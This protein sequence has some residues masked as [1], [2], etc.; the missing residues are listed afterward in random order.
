MEVQGL[1]DHFTRTVAG[2]TLTTLCG[3]AAA[4]QYHRASTTGPA[5]PGR[6]A[7]PGRHA[8]AMNVSDP[9]EQVQR[10]LEPMLTH[11]CAMLE[12]SH[13]EAALFFY[14]VLLALRASTCEEEL[15]GTFVL[16][17]TAAFQGL[18]YPPA[19]LQPIDHLLAVSADI[20]HTFMAPREQA[21]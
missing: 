3:T 8:G 2:W 4:I 9:I 10:T 11:I 13:P 5:P 19:A 14:E 16:L 6:Q 20:A 21:H 12:T 15:I 18:E 17:S 7:P 1:H